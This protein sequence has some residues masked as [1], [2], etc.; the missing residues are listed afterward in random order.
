[1]SAGRMFAYTFSAPNFRCA[2]TELRQALADV[3]RGNFVEES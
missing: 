3:T 1:M 2:M